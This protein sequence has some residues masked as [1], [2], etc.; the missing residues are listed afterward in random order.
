VFARVFG[1]WD[2]DRLAHVVYGFQ[3][4]KGS[5]IVLCSKLCLHVYW[6]VGQGQAGPGAAAGGSSK[7]H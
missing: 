6:Y 4:G 5:H 3:V 2:E 1:V 7:P